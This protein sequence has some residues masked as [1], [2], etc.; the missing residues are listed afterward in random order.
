MGQERRKNFLNSGGKQAARGR[1]Q[2]HLLT[3]KSKTFLED[4]K[5]K[6]TIHRLFLGSALS[7][8]SLQVWAQAPNIDQFFGNLKNKVIDGA[9][10]LQQWKNEAEAAARKTVSDFT[11]C[12]SPAAQNLYNDLKQKLNRVR[13]VK[14]L[15]E[16][17]DRKAQEARNNCKKVLPAGACDT[18]YN[19]LSFKATAAA[20]AGTIGTLETAMNA[21]KNLKCPSGCNRTGKILY[22]YFQLLATQAGNFPS[23]AMVPVGGINVPT[24][25]PNVSRILDISY[26]SAWN[27]GSFQAN[28]DAGNGEFSA[29]VR[30]KLPECRETKKLSCCSEWDLAVVLP[31][32]QKLNLIPPDVKISDLKISIPNKN[33]T[34]ISGVR[35]ASCNQT[36]KVPKRFQQTGTFINVT[37]NNSPLNISLANYTVA[38]WADIG[39]ASPAFGLEP[40]S[41]TT[42]VPDITRVK[43]EWQGVKVKTGSVEVDMTKPEFKG[44]CK[45]GCSTTIN[46]PEPQP[47]KGSLDLPWACL[48]P[49]FVNV[50]AQP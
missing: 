14:R 5:M 27:P 23:T 40:I 22:P 24:P 2:K 37:P 48:E 45:K 32:L 9:N 19:G 8:I 35:A 20:A 38:E 46:I 31:K 47:K 28:W 44:T 12:P 18:A 3:R 4:K 36:V 43:F 30:A 42:S 34:V 21:L 7:L 16:E 13:E 33:I 1:K 10:Q 11:D 49:R 50:V 39:C 41:N 25:T 26:C 6:L 17:E 29:E 15:A